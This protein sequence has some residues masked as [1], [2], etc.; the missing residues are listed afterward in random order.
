MESKEKLLIN[1]TER[2][3]FYRKVLIVVS[4]SQIFGGAGL[5]AGV[6][7]GALIAQEILGTEVYAGVPAALLTLG[8]AGAALM[9]GMLSQ[10]FGRR[11]GLGIG[12]MLGGL[13]AVLV[14]TA[15]ALNN[16]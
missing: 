13:G 9:I 8:S 10:K 11:Y 1:E 14:I 2:A 7:V 6:T 5:A 16:V 15:A 12:F 4:I 3:R